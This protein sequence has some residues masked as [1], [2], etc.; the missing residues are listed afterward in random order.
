MTTDTRLVA[1][2]ERISRDDELKGESNSILNQ[3]QIL[4]EYAERNGHY[5]ICHFTDDGISGT[6]I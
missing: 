1:L 2:Y 5:N 3:K 6:T 4:E